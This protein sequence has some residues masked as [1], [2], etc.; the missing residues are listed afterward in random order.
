MKRIVAAS[1]VFTNE[2]D[3]YNNHVVEILNHRVVNHYPL[4]GE[5]AMTEWLGGTIIISGHEA[6]HVGKVLSATELC[7]YNSCGNGHVERL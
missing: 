5:Q 7:T 3:F 2:K 4:E 1:R 6:F